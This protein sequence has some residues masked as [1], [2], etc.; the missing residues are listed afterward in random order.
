[1]QSRFAPQLM[2]LNAPVFINFPP[3]LVSDLGKFWDSLCTP[4]IELTC[5]PLL[6]RARH[7][8]PNCFHEDQ[9]ATSEGSCG[10]TDVVGVAIR[11]LV[12]HVTPFRVR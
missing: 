11:K 8:H 12:P 2:H 3:R 10:Y 4:L 5:K 6:L 1:M 9:I 7:W